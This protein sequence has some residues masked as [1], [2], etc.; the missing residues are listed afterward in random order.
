MARPQRG[1]SNTG[2]NSSSTNSG[3]TESALSGVF[4]I[5]TQADR[6]KFCGVFGGLAAFY[7][8]AYFRFISG[9]NEYT[10]FIYF[11]NLASLVWVS[12]R[13]WAIKDSGNKNDDD[14]IISR[15]VPLSIGLLILSGIYGIVYGVVAIMIPLL[16]SAALTGLIYAFADQ[17]WI[18]KVVSPLLFIVLFIVPI[19][20]F[21]SAK[22]FSIGGATWSY[23]QD[24]DECK[25][26]L[27]HFDETYVVEVAKYNGAFAP[28][29]F[30]GSRGLRSESSLID[31]KDHCEVKVQENA[32]KVINTGGAVIDKGGELIDSTVQKTKK[33]LKKTEEVYD[34]TKQKTKE[35]IEE[36]KKRKEKL[37][38][39]RAKIK[40]RK[41]K[42]NKGESAEDI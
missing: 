28:W 19:K 14:Q 6:K 10:F 37:D 36:A 4:K 22:L 7:A 18:F 1:A 16:V 2:N 15:W 34:S 20:L 41:K 11:A 12:W 38:K 40:K 30:P 3:S 21:T 13:F 5:D 33:V 23:I 29:F 8:L 27:K 42:S 24:C 31:Q 9:G 26:Y 39:T 25:E 32:C 17:K 35:V